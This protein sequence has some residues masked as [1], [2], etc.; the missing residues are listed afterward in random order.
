MR[1]VIASVFVALLFHAN[2][3][4]AQPA[5]G[6]PDLSL[7]RTSPN[8]HFVVTLVPPASVP[9]QEIH[10]WQVKVATPGG[11]PVS[12][13][14]VY[15][16]GGMPEH[17]HGLPT[18]PAVTREPVPGTYVVEGMKFSMPGMWELLVAVRKDTTSDVTAFNYLV[19][20]PPSGR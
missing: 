2:P 4:A 1:T 5:A 8:G 17:G 7:S 13:A 11:A 20:R 10:E 19:R 18:R 9:V 15:L 3:G 16:N 6:N 12:G 14:A